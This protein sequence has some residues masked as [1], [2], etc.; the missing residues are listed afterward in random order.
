MIPVELTAALQDIYRRIAAIGTGSG[1]G[2]S[3]VTADYVRAQL[4][5]YL[6]VDSVPT[7]LSPYA[8]I[9][10]VSRMLGGYLAKTDKV[11]FS[12]ISG[13]PDSLSLFSND[14]GY[15]TGAGVQ[16]AIKT[17]LSQLDVSTAVAGAL[18]TA[19]VPWGSIQDAPSSLSQFKNDI[20]VGAM[21]DAQFAALLTKSAV[22]W[23][24]ITDRPTKLSQF[25]NDLPAS[26]AAITKLS[27]LTDD[28][29][30]ATQANVNALSTQIAALQSTKVGLVQ[31]PIG[32]GVDT[33]E[34]TGGG[35]SSI[36]L[37]VV[38][39]D[40]RAWKSNLVTLRTASALGTTPAI[41][42][43]TDL[44]STGLVQA[45][46]G[47]F[48]AA[49]VNTLTVT[50]SIAGGAVDVLKSSLGGGGPAFTRVVTVRFYGDGNK[51][52]RHAITLTTVAGDGGSNVGHVLGWLELTHNLGNA[53]HFAVCTPVKAVYVLQPSWP[54]W[55]AGNGLPAFS[56][57]PMTYGTV[58]TT[59]YGQLTGNAGP[60]LTSSV[61][62]IDVTFAIQLY[63]Y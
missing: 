5:G 14:V 7:I 8:T 27:Q 24:I 1:A 54:Y 25:T 21:T 58:T 39:G 36:K 13:F 6:P 46:T 42:V 62:D 52:L 59:F 17:A 10:G 56:L 9:A 57:T 45:A 37:Q 43:E 11:P 26:S 47:N 50:G 44:I 31:N 61:S 29:G 38:P 15:A 48:G 28:V 32:G 18:K 34:L 55:E 20:G 35:S 12:N 16:A 33:L 19:S 53:N 4:S 30:L 3:G 63:T 22:P 41:K 51:S 40:P 2:N 49:S 23:S 60:W